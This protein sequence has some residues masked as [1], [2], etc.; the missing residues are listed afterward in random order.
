MS[1]L[2]I[3]Y[4]ITVIAICMIGIRYLLPVYSR[5]CMNSV[6]TIVVGVGFGFPALMAMVI[7][8]DQYLMGLKQ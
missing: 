8:A 6:K 2:T 7:W 4:P 5:P 3:I 1:Q